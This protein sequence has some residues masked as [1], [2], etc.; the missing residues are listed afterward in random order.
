MD[1][2]TYTLLADG[3]SDR[4]LIPIL[5]WLLREQCPEKCF[6][7]EVAD[8]NKLPKKPK[9]LEQRIEESIKQHPCDILFIHRDA[10]GASY[11]DRVKEIR[12]AIN[13]IPD[14]PSAAI[15]VVPVRMLEAWLLFDETAIRKAADNPNSDVDLDLPILKS[16]EN[17]KD[18]KD[19][20]KQR[21]IKSSGCT[22]KRCLK[23]FER[24]ISEKAFK[25][26]ENI[27]DFSPLLKLSAFKALED[28][29]TDE[30]NTMGI[31]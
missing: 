17:N 5:T 12:D 30:L 4:R 7:G 6:Q 22:T 28:E 2:I 19:E 20:L 1:E 25:V 15:C 11:K 9:G 26:A 8:F 18:P 16:L 13:N 23:R 31:S 21:L 10:E 14:K 3:S 29:L 24:D 27:E